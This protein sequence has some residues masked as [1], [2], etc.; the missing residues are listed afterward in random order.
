MFHFFI[1]FYFAP[2]P[3]GQPDGDKEKLDG[4]EDSA[5]GNEDHRD[6][7][8]EQLDGDEEQLDG[9]EDHCDLDL[10]AHSFH[11][12]NLGAKSLDLFFCRS[13]CDVLVS[14]FPVV[15]TFPWYQNRSQK[16]LIKKS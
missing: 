5:K 3:K 1:F 14:R 12:I 15:E 16:R 8:E 13:E 11:I 2:P 9:D 10:H 4:D 7:D 6:G